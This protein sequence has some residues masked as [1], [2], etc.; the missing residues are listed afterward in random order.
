MI[1]E[2]RF[3]KEKNRPWA[4]VAFIVDEAYQGIGVATYLYKMLIRLAK[5]RG[6]QGFTADVLASNKAMMKV[7]EKGGAIV[8]AQLEYGIYHLTIPFEAKPSP[9]KN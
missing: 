5:D 6:I 8:K 1:A 2:A 7:F 3:I 4:E 9:L